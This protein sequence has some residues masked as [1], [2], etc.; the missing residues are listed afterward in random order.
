MRISKECIDC[1]YRKEVDMTKDEDYLAEIREL[2]ENWDEKLSAP[3][4][5]YVI[6]KTY[7]KRYGKPSRYAELKKQYNDLLLSMEDEISRKIESSADPLM[8]SLFMARIGN[9]IDFA[10]MKNVDKDEFLNLLTSFKVSEDD[11]KT[12]SSFLYECGH[13]HN[14]LL[15]ADNC[16]EIVL[17]R[18][19]LTKLKQRFPNLDITVLVRGSEVLNDVTEEDALYV[20]IDKVA[21]IVS[22]GAPLAGTEYFMLSDEAKS[23]LDSADIILSKGQGNYESM[24]NTSRHVFFLFLCKCDVFTRYFG[25]ERLTG[26]FIE[27]K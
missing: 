20:G 21:R 18:I 8:T 23:V 1:L 25:V 15:L 16:G 17:D 2:L 10:A 9:Y 27:E 11:M 13:A 6:N 26:M 3:Y 7:E 14:F 19:M 24:V 5:E 22:S 12:Y 4:M